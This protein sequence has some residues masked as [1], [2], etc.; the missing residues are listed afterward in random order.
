MASNFLNRVESGMP[1]L[2]KLAKPW[3]NIAGLQVDH[4][5]NR[6]RSMTIDDPVIGLELID[7]ETGET[8]P[9]PY[10]VPVF[11]FGWT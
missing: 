5:A 2:S 3:Y 11:R 10:I 1:Q 8:R 4:R 9:F 7:S 6:N